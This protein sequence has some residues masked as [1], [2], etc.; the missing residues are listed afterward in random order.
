MVRGRDV[1]PKSVNWKLE[2]RA[3]GGVGRKICVPYP[4]INNKWKCGVAQSAGVA[5][6]APVSED[7]LCGEGAEVRKK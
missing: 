6:F 3:G 4:K 5:I 7:G 1:K 2:A